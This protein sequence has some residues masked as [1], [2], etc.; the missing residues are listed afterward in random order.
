MLIKASRF[1]NLPEFPACEEQGG[2]L[3]LIWRECWSGRKLRAPAERLNIQPEVQQILL[4]QGQS[5][6]PTQ[7]LT[8]PRAAWRE[9]I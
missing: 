6:A 8:V 5:P 4:S 1:K 9:Q 7:P 2:K 3:T